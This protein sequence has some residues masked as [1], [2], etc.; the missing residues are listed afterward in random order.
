MSASGTRR[1]RTPITRSTRSSACCGVSESTRLSVRARDGHQPRL[2]G[3]L[4]AGESVVVRAMPE[5]EWATIEA[6][7]RDAG[8]GAHVAAALPPADGGYRGRARAAAGGD[9]PRHSD[10]RRRR[11][12][13]HRRLLG[14]RG[15]G[16]RRALNSA[17]SRPNSGR[18]RE[19]R[20]GVLRA[21]RPWEPVEGSR[22]KVAPHRAE[23]N[24]RRGGVRPSDTTAVFILG[25][26]NLDEDTLKAYR[27]VAARKGAGACCAPRLNGHSIV[28]VPKPSENERK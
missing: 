3:R 2:G 14:D 27:T 7:V 18:G 16:R 26:L 25:E 4:P 5:A 19:R 6:E 8:S 24:V 11:Q 12:P 20:V 21:V 9:L 22:Q 15:G 23:R 28:L 10:G 1:C 13:C 17:D